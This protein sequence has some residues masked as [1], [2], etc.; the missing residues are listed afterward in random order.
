MAQMPDPDSLTAAGLLI[1]THHCLR[2]MVDNLTDK[3][4]ATM[5]HSE[6]TLVRA[7]LRAEGSAF[8][9]SVPLGAGKPIAH[10]ARDLDIEQAVDEAYEDMRRL[11]RERG[12]D[13]GYAG[14]G[15]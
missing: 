9:S 6:E 11:A 3:D 10:I 14:E 1:A 12:L 5:A 4:L 7:A 15:W 8:L 2:K 13:S